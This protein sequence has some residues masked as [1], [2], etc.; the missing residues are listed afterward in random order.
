MANI[1]TLIEGSEKLTSI[2][3]FW[4][5]FHDAEVVD[6]QLWRGDGITE[7]SNPRFPVLTTRIHV[8]ELTTEIDAR[9]YYVLK[10]HTLAT[11][12]FHDV[13]DLQV[14][15]FNH[16]NAIFGLSI[17]GKERSEGPWKYSFAVLFD[18]SFGIDASFQCS[19]IE[20]VDAIP[21]VQT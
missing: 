13:L 9:G 8:W 16:Q 20:V 21:W 17:T 5:S 3:G 18:P 4:P 14:K 2:F 12:R 19:R 6:L 1:D 15:G 10:H 11:L 7:R